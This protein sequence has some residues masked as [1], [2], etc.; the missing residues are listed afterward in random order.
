MGIETEVELET[1]PGDEQESPDICNGDAEEPSARLSAKT[2]DLADEL[3]ADAAPGGTQF[4]GTGERPRSR[5]STRRIVAFGVLPALALVLAL[6]AGFLKWQ[7][8]SV[9]DAGD[10]RTASVQSAKDSTV[11]ILSYRPD[12]VER[13]LDAARDRLTGGF[14]DSYSALIRDVIIPGAKQRQISTVATAP[15]AASVSAEPDHAVVMVFVNQTTTVGTDAPTDTASTVRVALDKV[16]GHWLVS[17][18][19]PI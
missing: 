1:E 2:G 19:D 10:A 11:A 3:D 13:D 7:D 15:A 6:S 9:R 12:T 4:G 16:D 18:F 8:A 5:R 17:Q 14:R